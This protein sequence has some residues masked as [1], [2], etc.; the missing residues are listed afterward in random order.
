LV[1]LPFLPLADI[2]RNGELQATN[3]FFTLGDHEIAQLEEPYVRHEVSG[4]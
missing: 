2:V 1:S 3:Y 4:H